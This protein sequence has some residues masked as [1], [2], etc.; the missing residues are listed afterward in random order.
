MQDQAKAN[1]LLLL[2]PLMLGT[3]TELT[4]RTGPSGATSTPSA[5]ATPPNANSD[6][7]AVTPLSA[8]T[9]TWY[10][11]AQARQLSGGHNGDRGG[12]CVGMAAAV[13]W[14]WTKGLWRRW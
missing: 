1:E 7:D 14:W 4:R 11:C 3:C 9:T 8:V 13:R 5:V 12:A 6:T 10:V 2:L